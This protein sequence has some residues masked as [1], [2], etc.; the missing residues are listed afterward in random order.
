MFGSRLIGRRVKATPPNATSAM[1]K[2]QTVARRFR[3]NSIRLMLG[4]PCASAAARAVGDEPEVG[5]LGRRDDL[6]RG[7]LLQ[8]PLTGDDH[9]LPRLE[10]GDRLD[11]RPFLQ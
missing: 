11:A 2:L 6:D 8:P 10:S 5:G 1:A 9:L 4:G 3:E 7:A